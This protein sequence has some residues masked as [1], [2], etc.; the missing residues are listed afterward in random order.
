MPERSI[1]S[2]I[3]PNGAGK[4]TF[5]N[6]LT[7]FY[8]PTYGRIEFDGKNVTGG[9]PDVIMKL[10]HGADVPEHPPVRD[11]ERG[12]E[13]HGRP[14]L[15]HEGGPVRL[16]HPHPRRPQGG[17]ARS[18]EKAREELSYVGVAKRHHD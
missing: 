18:S 1:V 2:I 14:E 11:D 13:L 15:A 6:M 12:R 8:K 9:R 16:D 4:T 3:G 5:F 17:E 7:G 10:G